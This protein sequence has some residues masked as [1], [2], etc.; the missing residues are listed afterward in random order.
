M[1]EQYMY[2]CCM[3]ISCVCVCVCVCVYV[4]CQAKV[5]KTGQKVALKIIK[6]EPGEK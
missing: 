6:I 3:Y 5:V 4:C 2:V 1:Y